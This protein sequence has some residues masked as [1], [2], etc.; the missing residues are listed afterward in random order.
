MGN[1]MSR[2]KPNRNVFGI[3]LRVLAI[4]L[5]LGAVRS[6]PYDYYV[7]LRWVACAAAVFVAVQAHIHVKSREW[8][9]WSFGAMAVFFNPIAPIHLSR[10]TW[11]AIDLLA[12]IF[13]AGSFWWLRTD[14][15]VEPESM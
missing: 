10:L 14:V 13:L 3:I 2:A 6:M 4:V 8:V 12:A 7:V 1:H 5:L 15:G 11:V 9:S